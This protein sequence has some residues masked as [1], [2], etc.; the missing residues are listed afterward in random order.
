M[1]TVSPGFCLVTPASRGLGFALTLHLLKHTNLP[2]V[3]TA[4]RDCTDVYE[5]LLDE[6][7]VRDAETATRL[8]ALPLMLLVYS[9]L[10]TFGFSTI[11]TELIK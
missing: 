10:F 7:G 9:L 1:G 11:N 6:V 4:R 8:M 3:T 2:V 5:R